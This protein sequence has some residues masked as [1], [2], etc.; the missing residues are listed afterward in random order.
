VSTGEASQREAGR[1]G[2]GTPG[3]GTGEASQPEA[4]AASTPEQILLGY[5]PFARAAAWTPAGTG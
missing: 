4:G 3:G 5:D 1:P 2:L